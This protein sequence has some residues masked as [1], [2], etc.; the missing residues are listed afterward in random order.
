MKKED[1]AD[2]GNDN[3]FLDQLVPQMVDSALDEPRAVVGPHDFD[4]R[5]QPFFE[6]FKLGLYRNDGLQRVLT[7]SHHD[8]ATHRLA[9]AAEF[10]DAPPHFRP[11]LDVRNVLEEYRCTTLPH[12]DRYVPK[13]FQRLEIS[14]RA[15]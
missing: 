14:S 6:G 2:E 9:L 3:E 12:L 13:I 10:R 4:A 1:G 7:R 5:R 8:H 15:D 11:D